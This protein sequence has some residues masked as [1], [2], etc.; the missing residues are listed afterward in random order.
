MMD[1]QQINTALAQAKSNLHATKG[2]A[3][4]MLAE[5]IDAYTGICAG[6]INQLITE[7]VEL[8]KKSQDLKGDKKVD[9]K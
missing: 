2:R 9:K 4:G 8:Q 6:I 1:V 5:G 3:D 7:N